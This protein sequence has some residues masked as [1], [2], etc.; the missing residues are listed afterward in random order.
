MEIKFREHSDSSYVGRTREN[1]TADATIAIASNFHSGGEKLTK[2]LVEVNEKTYISI[3]ISR[4]LSISEELIDLIVNK[5]NTSLKG[6]LLDNSIVLNIAGNGIYTMRARYSQKE[7]DKYLMDLLSKIISSPKLKVV[8][9]L[10]RSG[11]QTGIDEAGAKASA[12]LGMDTLVVFPKGWKYRDIEG[13]DIA[14]EELFK[15]RFYE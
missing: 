8:I 12:K 15:K 2:R 5:L 10:V 4:D 6:N 13:A 14:N 7:L 1:A 11:G 9:K 3:D